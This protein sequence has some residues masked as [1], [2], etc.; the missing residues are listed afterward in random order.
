MNQ[1]N[2]NKSGIEVKED[3]VELAQFQIV[4]CEALKPHHY[5]VNAATMKH[6]NE[7]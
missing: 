7:N 6:Q 2:E 3:A 5:K 4:C 1:G